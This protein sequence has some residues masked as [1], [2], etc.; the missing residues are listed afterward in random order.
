MYVRKKDASGKITYAEWL[1]VR[2]RHV[3]KRG[4][5]MMIKSSASAK[6]DQVASVFYF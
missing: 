6:N 3:K 5:A 4:R 1:G 2:L